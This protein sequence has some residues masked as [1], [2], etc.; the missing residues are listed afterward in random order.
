MVDNTENG[1][2]VVIAEFPPTPIEGTTALY[3]QLGTRYQNPVVLQARRAKPSRGHP[4]DWTECESDVPN[5]ESEVLSTG[6]V[7]GMVV[8]H[9]P[10]PA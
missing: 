2:T 5:T 7:A 4:W 1:D 9:V 10:M 6:V 8:A 3:L